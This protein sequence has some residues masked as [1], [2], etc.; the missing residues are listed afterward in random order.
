[1]S[2]GQSPAVKVE[3]MCEGVRWTEALGAAALHSYPNYYPYRFRK[4]EPNPTGKDTAVIPY[5][6]RMADGTMMRVFGNGRSPWHVEGSRESGYRLVDDQARRE[7]G[8]TFIDA[9]TWIHGQTR[10]GFPLAQ[11]GVSN[12]D[13]MMVINVAPGCEYFLHKHD[14]DS[15]RCRFC[16]YG[17][18]DQRTAHLGQ[19][20]GQVGIPQRTLER[21]CDGMDAIMRDIEIRH[22]YLVGGSLT[23]ARQ[24]GERFMQ[25]ARAVKAHVGNRIPVTL[26]SGALPHDV[27]EDFHRQ[28]LVD[29]VC[30]NL[31][32]WS[33]KLFSQICPGKHRY[34]GYHNWIASLEKAVSLWGRGRV[35]S[36]MVSGIELEPE[37]GLTFDEAADLELQGAEDLCS[38]GIIPIYSLS[39][40]SGGRERPDYHQ[41]LRSFFEKIN[42]GYAQIRQQ[43]GL[44]IWDGFMCHRC[45]YMQLECDIDRAPDRRAA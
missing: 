18:P 8:I 42:A 25:L 36:A 30:F 35:Y 10:D 34:V 22:I 17:A 26:G 37:Y 23:D 33:E 4:D 24:E 44:A 27:L 12:H 13:D 40:P 1:M 38:R 5:M 29:A 39:W 16:A 7:Y 14:G 43:H 28:E 20:A 15:M 6:M 11:V 19:V 31:E 21:M 3:I 9:D 41:Q 2:I 45:A 32:I